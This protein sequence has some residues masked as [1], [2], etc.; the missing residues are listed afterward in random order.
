MRYK[1]EAGTT[2]DRINWDVRVVNEIFMDNAPEKTGYNTEMHRLEILE[3]MEVQTSEPYSPWQNK[4]ESIIKIIK[5]KSKR[6]IFQR[7]ISKRIWDLD[8]VWEAEIYSRTAGKD[9]RPSLEN[10]TGDT[11]YI[12]EWLEFEFYE[13]VWFGNKHSDNTKPMLVRWL[14]V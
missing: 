14:G 11:I 2:L 4:A 7:N 12:S 5:G 10:L 8:M 6:R 1:S 3:R 9:G 13:L